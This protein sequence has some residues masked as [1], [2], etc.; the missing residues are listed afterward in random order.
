V[1]R[2]QAT[3]KAAPD[4]KAIRTF[5]DSLP[6]R[7]KLFALLALNCGMNNVDIGLLRRNQIDWKERTLTRKRVKTEDKE[8]VPTVTYALWAETVRLLR[9]EQNTESEFVLTAKGGECL[10]VVGK[11]GDKAKLYDRIKS[12]WRDHF[13]RGG[14]KEYTLIQ[15][16]FFGADLLKANLQY[17]SYREPFLGHA[18]HT[19]AEISY[20]SDEDVSV[21]CR[22]LEKLFYP[23]GK[24]PASKG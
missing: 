3:S 12:Q 24:K 5:L 6:E 2:T 1:F 7:L 10:Y 23:R 19:T 11:V 9:Q 8:K 21:A 20:S 18:P 17:R 4:V 13:G 14:K 22:Y 16:R 15:F